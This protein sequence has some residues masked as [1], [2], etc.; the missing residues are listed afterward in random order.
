[1]NFL[2]K[3]LQSRYFFV[4]LF[5]ILFQ[6]LFGNNYFPYEVKTNLINWDLMS[7]IQYSGASGRYETPYIKALDSN[8]NYQKFITELISKN[9]VK[10]KNIVNKNPEMKIGWYSTC[11]EKIMSWFFEH[12]YWER[13]NWECRAVIGF[14]NK[15][16]VEIFDYRKTLETLK[17][18]YV[19][20][21]LINYRYFFI[22]VMFILGHFSYLIIRKFYLLKTNG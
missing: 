21:A 15:D 2:K 20:Y 7:N 22:G 13:F 1:M 17:E 4:G 16:D 11:F 18:R 6:V 12:S 5:L 10:I 19:L 3:N 9:K 14:R 8:G